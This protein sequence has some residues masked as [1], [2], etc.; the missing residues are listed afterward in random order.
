MKKIIFFSKDLNIGGMEQA[1]VTLLNHIDSSEYKISL[2]LEK[3][4]GPF[5]NNLNNNIKVIDYSLS[6]IQNVFIRKSINF[7]KKIK[8][9]IQNHNKY[10]CSINF[11][12]YSIL[13]SQLSRMC[14][15]NNILFIHS[16]Y[17]NMYDGNTEEINAFFNLIRAK[18][19][20]KLVFISKQSMDNILHIIPELKK[21]S[22]IIG[23][24]VDVN[25]ILRKSTEYNIELD[26]S[27][28][29]LLYVGRL[30]EN[31]KQLS[32]L[33]N[34]VNSSK[35]KNQ[36]NLYILGSGPDSKYY[37]T[38]SKSSNIFFIG[39]QE[40]PYP[41]IKACDYIILSSKFEGFPM[42]YNEANLLGTKI[43]TT[44]PAADDEISYDNNNTIILDKDLKN[45]D[46]IIQQICNNTLN[47]ASAN[48]DFNQMNN[49]KLNKFYKLI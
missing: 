14:S 11:A 18:S 17:Y 40:N 1:L 43:I 36:F 45:F 13:C 49:N 30:E 2:V 21:K 29:S 26:T 28:I 35:Q 23:N 16:D 33:I 48:I 27:K 8:F 38:L 34:T 12:T 44:I 3:A 41:Y 10:D 39:E 42:V 31:S 22:I 37:K 5:L 6:N 19:F 25:N 46:S 20:Q 15:K 9:I 32:K 47:I 24:L 4:T 7:I